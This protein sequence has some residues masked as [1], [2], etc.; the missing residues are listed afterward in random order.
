MKIC[1]WTF[2]H[3]G[4][5]IWNHSNF[6][7]NCKGTAGKIDSSFSFSRSLIDFSSTFESRSIELNSTCFIT[8]FQLFFRAHGNWNEH[9]FSINGFD[10]EVRRGEYDYSISHYKCCLMS[11]SLAQ[12]FASNENNSSTV[13]QHIIKFREFWIIFHNSTLVLFHCASFTNPI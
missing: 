2:D 12:V 5:L 1:E 8:R 4:K 10:L 13:V 7:L 9:D 6:T 11:S 3:S